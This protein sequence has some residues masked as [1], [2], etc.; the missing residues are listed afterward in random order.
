MVNKVELIGFLGVNPDFRKTPDG[1]QIATAKIA[2]TR[3]YRN[4]NG[5]TCRE[6]EWHRLVFFGE[7]AGF[8]NTTLRKG[9]LVRIEGRLKTRKWVRDGQD[10]YT[11]EI[12]VNE[13]QILSKKEGVGEEAQEEK[14]AQG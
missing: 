11:T 13:V 1:V 5:E 12:I 3:F 6:T 7:L 10:H 14:P 4:A 2:T 8:A 9:M